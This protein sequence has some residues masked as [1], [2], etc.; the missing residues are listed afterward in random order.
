M[1]LD[2]AEFELLVIDVELEVV[3]DIMELVLLAICDVLEMSVVVEEACGEDVLED[4]I[5]EE[6]AIGLLLDEELGVLEIPLELLLL[7]AVL[8]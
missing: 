1:I 3:L 8:L 6:G 4:D 5:L 7:D 2:V